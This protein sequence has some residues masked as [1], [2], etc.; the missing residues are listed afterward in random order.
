MN[1]LDLDVLVSV[2]AG[3]VAVATAVHGYVHARARANRRA[4]EELEDT[5]SAQASRLA[6]LEERVNTHQESLSGIGR[7]HARIDDVAQSTSHI[8]GQ[9]TQ[10]NRSVGLLTEHLLSQK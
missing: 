7:M 8:D 2:A 3:T 9:L 6:V 4:L 10:L 1:L 5:V